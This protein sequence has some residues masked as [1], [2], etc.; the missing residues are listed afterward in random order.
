ML[1]TRV[2]I[3]QFAGMECSGVAGVNLQKFSGS[4]VKENE[5]I[6]K[7]ANGTKVL[8]IKI[9]MTAPIFLR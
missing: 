2:A 7:V 3:I 4:S 6:L 1:A 9:K 5:K 8:L